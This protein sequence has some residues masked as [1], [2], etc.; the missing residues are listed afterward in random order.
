[1]S[2]NYASILY[3]KR[4]HVM[5]EDEDLFMTTANAIKKKSY[6]QSTFLFFRFDFFRFFEPVH[7]KQV[8][9]LIH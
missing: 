1:M 8:A 2:F 4:N 6:T 5:V 9:S 3:R 7:V